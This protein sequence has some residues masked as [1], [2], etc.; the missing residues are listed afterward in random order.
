ME[1]LLHHD[2][3]V[4]VELMPI[5]GNIPKAIHRV[6]RVLE[7]MEHGQRAVGRLSR[8]GCVFRT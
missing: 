5:V 1:G 4:A 2:G 8:A 3:V 7:G 6:V